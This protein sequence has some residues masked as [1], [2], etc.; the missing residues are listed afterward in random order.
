M[1]RSTR[2]SAGLAVLLVLATGTTLFSSPERVAASDDTV[3]T[4]LQ[5]GWNLA[6]WTEAEAGVD[7]IF[8][9][10]PQLEVAY[11]W[12]A[13]NQRF[14]LAVRTDAGVEGDLRTLTPGM[15]LWLSLGGGESFTWTR[16]LVPQAGKVSLYRGW[17]LA[18]W[19]GE[20]RAA[21]T[22]ALQDLDDVLVAA[23]R[24]DGRR[25]LTLARGDVVWLDL[26]ADRRWDQLYRPPVFD[27]GSDVPPEIQGEVRTSIDNIVEFFYQRLGVRA[28][29]V[30]IRYGDATVFTCGEYRSATHTI[31]IRDDGCSR[32]LVHEYVHALQGE[33][34]GNIDL[35]P[36]WL[37]EG[38]AEYWADVYRDAVGSEGYVKEF[39]SSARNVERWGFIPITPSYDFAH[40]AA[41]ALAK[42]VGEDTMLSYFRALGTSSRAGWQRA[43]QEA[44]GMDVDEFYVAYATKFGELGHAVACPTSW[45]I[46]GDRPEGSPDEVCRTLS[47]RV[48]DRNGRPRSGVLV[49]AASDNSGGDAIASS[50]TGSS[51]RFSMVLPSGTYYVGLKAAFKSIG[52]TTGGR[53]YYY[54]G[55]SGFAM[56]NYEATSV[57]LEAGD[58]EDIT[59]ASALI[60]G[61]VRG[62]AG[63]LLRGVTVL[64]AW[65]SPVGHWRVE[66]VVVGY[67]PV[68]HFPPA[69]EESGQFRSLVG[70][71]AYKI[72]VYCGRDY[73]TGKFAGWFGGQQGLVSALSDAVD[74]VVDSTDVTGVAINLPFTQDEVNEKSCSRVDADE[75]DGG[76]E[77]PAPIDT[78]GYEPPRIEFVMEL[79]Q[80]HKDEVK[81]LVDDV[82]EFFYERLGVRASGL[83]IRYGDLSIAPCGVYKPG[84]HTV[85]IAHPG[86]CF[87]L[88]PHEYVHALQGQM[89]E[90]TFLGLPWIVEGS[91]DYWA[92][93]YY[94][95]RGEG[96]YVKEI[97]S[98][99]QH[100]EKVGFIP[101][102][103]SY[104]FAHLGVH[105][106][107]KA[108]GE[109]S[110]A[111]YFAGSLVPARDGW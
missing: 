40:L 99:I 43:F 55:P 39:W 33:L 2:A 80:E 77:S 58:V 103:A 22:D 44:T 109:D 85:T 90:R 91:A 52:H 100:A 96:D 38:S 82:V 47:G 110:L 9:D 53:S 79:T 17:N 68:A 18:I 50:V 108:F 31:A 34:A 23:R 49:A 63:E 86:R 46:P 61:T 1:R 62:R 92:A 26:S 54:G 10:I 42:M 89:R 37:V 20:D 30:T 72:A 69:T 41:H 94:D 60:S 8:D 59:I 106:L 3:T 14:R 73:V 74:I 21:A 105:Y 84:T 13:E 27:F 19:A 32:A 67:R 83:T 25:P 102:A 65:P 51:G 7:A 81:A 93:A 97:R 16:P 95:A 71:G 35:V 76:S 24:I 75:D 29:G 6:G 64:P 4:V 70:P 48:T 87:H 11:A 66:G 28:S 78:E 12:D 98:R 15:G 5:P 104:E 57:S 56:A 101:I 111:S 107:V 36:R 45:Y 88:I